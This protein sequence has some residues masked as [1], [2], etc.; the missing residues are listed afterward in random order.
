MVVLM[1]DGAQFVGANAAEIVAQMRRN[2]W[3]SPPKKG[4][5]MAEV[6]ERIQ[7]IVNRE[8]RTSDPALF[9]SDLADAG[10]CVRLNDDAAD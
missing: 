5:Y 1:Q 3:S 7:Q 10:F 8:I 6:A 4:E 9:L 2:D